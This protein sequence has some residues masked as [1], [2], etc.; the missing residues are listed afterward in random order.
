MLVASEAPGTSTHIFLSYF[1]PYFFFVMQR[2][3]YLQT[4]GK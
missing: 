4:N 2:A 1:F 3:W